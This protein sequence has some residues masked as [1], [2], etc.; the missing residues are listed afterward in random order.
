M[1]KLGILFLVVSFLGFLDSTYLTVEH[2]RGV[3]PPCTIIKG[4]DVV[5]TSSYSVVA[6]IPVALAGSLFYLTIFFLS[7]WYLDSKKERALKLAAYLTFFGLLGSAWF[8]YVQLGILKAICIYCMG[9]AIS[10][11]TLFISGLFVLKNK[12][13]TI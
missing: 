4:C 6:G 3:I 10:S 9:S 5:T 12:N 8:V 13:K 2:Y 11:T 7:V 1:K